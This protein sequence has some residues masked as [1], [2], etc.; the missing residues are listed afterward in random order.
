M[1]NANTRNF[2][3]WGIVIALLLGMVVASNAPGQGLSNDEITYSVLEQK[4][5]AGEV[6]TAKIDTDRGIIT[7]TFTN[8]EKY[9]ANIGQFNLNADAVFEGS[10]VHYEY[11]EQTRPN[12]LGS[13]LVGKTRHI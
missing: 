4:V 5:D 7:G 6:A 12:M 3:V 10:E 2:I 8:G 11:K 13:M 1:K 9:S